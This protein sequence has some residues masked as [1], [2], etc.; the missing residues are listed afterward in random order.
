MAEEMKAFSIKVE[1]LSRAVDKAVA[2]VMGQHKLQASKGLAFGPGTLIGRQLQGAAEAVT[3]D[4][5][6]HGLT[7]CPHRGTQRL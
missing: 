2:D 1:D 7:D 6:C 3:V 5:R 4:S